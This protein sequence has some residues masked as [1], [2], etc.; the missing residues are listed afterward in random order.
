MEEVNVKKKTTTTRQHTRAHGGGGGDGGATTAYLTSLHFLCANAAIRE[1]V[2][3]VL[4][5]ALF[6]SVA[7][8]VVRI[9]SYSDSV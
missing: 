7:V 1:C 3:S 5:L 4:K 9:S 6:F 2:T 8:V